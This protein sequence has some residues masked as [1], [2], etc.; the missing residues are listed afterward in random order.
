MP[1]GNCMPCHC[2]ADGKSPSRTPAPT[3]PLPAAAADVAWLAA[4]LEGAAKG[5]IRGVLTRPHGQVGSRRQRWLPLPAKDQGAAGI[6]PRWAARLLGLGFAWAG[7]GGGCLGAA[8]AVQQKS[9]DACILFECCLLV[10][11]CQA[12][13]IVGMQHAALQQPC[14]PQP[15]PPAPGAHT[16]PHAVAWVQAPARA[17]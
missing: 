13:G 5:S 9:S 10:N 12:K 7:G 4:H 1:T 3:C 17:A 16:P 15:P 14:A 11:A 2:T 6:L 8:A